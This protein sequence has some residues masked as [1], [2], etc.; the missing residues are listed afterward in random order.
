MTSGKIILVVLEITTET[1]PP[2]FYRIF[3][4][5][6]WC[7]IPS[8]FKYFLIVYRSKSTSMTSNTTVKLK[9]WRTF[10]NT[11]S[12]AQTLPISAHE[13]APMRAFSVLQKLLK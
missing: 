3:L 9:S 7:Q 8:I 10:L 6:N 2:S 12:G 13:M 4:H 5:V 11:N 1:S